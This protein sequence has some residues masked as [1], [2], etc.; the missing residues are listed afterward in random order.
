[1]CV[2]YAVCDATAASSLTV[3]VIGFAFVF[4]NLA[5]SKVRM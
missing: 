3:S 1:M 4:D 2:E 5:L